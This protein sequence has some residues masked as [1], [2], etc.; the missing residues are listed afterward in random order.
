MPKLKSGFTLFEILIV[1]AIV[2]IVYSLVFMPLSSKFESRKKQD[3]SL[4]SITDKF[5]KT[6]QNNANYIFSLECSSDFLDCSFFDNHNNKIAKPFALEVKNPKEV[7]ILD[8]NGPNIVWQ[9]SFGNFRLVFNNAPKEF[10]IQDEDGVY[11]IGALSKNNFIATNKDEAF[12]KAKSQIATSMDML[13][14]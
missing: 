9:N 8:T 4:L 11:K 5:N 13:A 10:F 12:Q 6:K 3:N 1:V 7:Y 2:G 14:K